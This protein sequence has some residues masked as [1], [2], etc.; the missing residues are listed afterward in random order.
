MNEAQVIEAL[1][2]LPSARRFADAMALDCL[3]GRNLLILTGAQ[4]ASECLRRLLDDALGRHRGPRVQ[5]INLDIFSE[6]E[7]PS[8]FLARHAVSNE[9]VFLPGVA[10]LESTSLPD[11]VFL[12]FGLERLPAAAQETWA[13]YFHAWTQYPTTHT[14][15]L[16]LATSVRP[17]KLRSTTGDTRLAVHAWWRNLSAL[18][19]H[20]LCKL[21][22]DTNEEWAAARWREAVL[23]HVA[24]CDTRL[25]AGLWD[26]VLQSE[27]ELA[28][29]LRKHGEGL[30]LS[31]TP[32]TPLW[33][34]LRRASGGNADVSMLEGNWGLAWSLGAAH[35]SEEHGVEFT[36]TALAVLDERTDLR[37]RMW[38]GQAA[39]LLPHLDH[40]RISVCRELSATRGTDWPIRLGSHLFAGEERTRVETNPLATEFGPL[41]IIL[42]ESPRAADRRFHPVVKR[43]RN[44]RNRLA[45][46][47]P[48]FLSDYRELLAE[49]RA[50]KL[51]AVHY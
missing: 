42:R 17:G 27:E 19:I 20:L 41:E 31:R 25:V 24:G 51:G 48:I 39:L 3:Q 49:Q 4:L 2:L 10:Q 40:L 22:T 46:Y 18:E 33:Q 43:A 45:H 26:A 5:A 50:V 1:M 14:H 28:A 30:G 15:T 35:G 36:A 47:Q 8:A 12:I 34:G 9:D 32:L 13:K 37:H 23:P 16:A 44:L 11:T 21:C 38:R 29:A 7:Q 6:T